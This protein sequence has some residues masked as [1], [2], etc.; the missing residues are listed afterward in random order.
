MHSEPEGFSKIVGVVTAKHSLND[1]VTL[2]LKTEQ[3]YIVNIIYELRDY[4]TNS[5]LYGTVQKGM[6]VSCRV[7]GFFSPETQ[8]NYRAVGGLRIHEFADELES[9]ARQHM[10]GDTGEDFTPAEIARIAAVCEQAKAQIRLEFK[11]NEEVA[12]AVDR[13]LDQIAQSS[14]TESKIQWKRLFMSAVVRI[15]IELG[16]GATIPEALFTV[17]KRVIA[18][19]IEAR[20]L[21]RK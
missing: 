17:F 11:P 20:F 19:V 10:L 13:E 21:P 6:L 7:K 5:N 14:K 3:G 16:F 4:G 15:A 8:L 18:D 1:N 9:L 12:K 2:M